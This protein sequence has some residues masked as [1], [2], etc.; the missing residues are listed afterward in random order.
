MQQHRATSFNGLAL[1]TRAIA[2]LQPLAASLAGVQIQ[3]DGTAITPANT[4]EI[5]LL[6]GSKSVYG[7]ISGANLALINAYKGEASNTLVQYVQ[8]L[9]RDGRTLVD[10]EVGAVDIPDL[11]GAAVFVA[12]RNSAGSGTPTL[13]ADG[14]YVGRQAKT[15][16]NTG[17][18]QPL[19]RRMCKLKRYDLPGAGTTRANYQDHFNG[20]W[21]KRLFLQYTGTNWTSTTAGNLHTVEVRLGGRAVHDRIGAL[22]N[23]LLQSR[24][25]RTPQANMYVVDFVLDGNILQKAVKPTRERPLEIYC[26]ATAADTVTMWA[27][28]LDLPENN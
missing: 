10:Q 7:P 14:V 21:I 2:Q 23:R 17:R 18:V 13:E 3:G 5:E 22:R 28:L 8:L 15:N 9:E 26:E 1:G 24:Y 16:P 11:N 20:A 19:T 12:L 6:I 4:A 27:E 25:G